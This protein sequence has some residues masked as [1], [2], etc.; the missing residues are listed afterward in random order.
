LYSLVDAQV[1][2]WEVLEASY[3]GFGDL[4]N[5]ERPICPRKMFERDEAQRLR[6]GGLG[7][8]MVVSMELPKGE[9]RSPHDALTQVCSDLPLPLRIY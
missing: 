5:D 6:D 1:L 4:L 7:S 8:V 2:P 9:N 3:V